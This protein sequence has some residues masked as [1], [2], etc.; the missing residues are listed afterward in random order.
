MILW[1][2]IH[3]LLNNLKFKIILIVGIGTDIL[4]VDRM[5]ERIKKEPEFIHSVFTD[6]EIKYCEKYKFKEQNYAARFAAKEA[7]MK[8]LGT[9]WNDGISYNEISIINI[10]SGKPEIVLVG[11]TLELANKIGVSEIHVS[12]SHSRYYAIAYVILEAII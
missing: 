10:Q 8:A 4:E 9:G 7:L 12:L 11:K 5:K 1:V 2:T 6:S 3:N